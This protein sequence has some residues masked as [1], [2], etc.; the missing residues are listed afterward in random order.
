MNSAA[1]YLQRPT[2]SSSDVPSARTVP[3]YLWPAIIVVYA[4][5]MPRELTVSIGT[6]ALFPYRLALLSALPFLAFQA[7]R[8]PVRLHWIDGLVALVSSWILLSLI[9]HES[10]QQALETGLA[11]SL[12]FCLAYLVGR[13][14]I[15]STSDFRA[16][17]LAFLPGLTFIAA[18][19]LYESVAHQ[20]VLRPLIAELVGLPPPEIHDQVRF[21]L[22]R[23]A[24]P[25]PHPIL[26]GVMLATLLPVAWLMFDRGWLR[27]VSVFVAFSMI[28]T[29]STAAILVFLTGAVLM[30][31]YEVQRRSGIPVW[32]ISGIVAATL[33]GLIVAVSESGL[34]SFAAR[35]VSISEASGQWRV[36]IWEFASQEVARHPLF[37]IGLRDWERPTW[38]FTD[39]IDAHFL[40]WSVRFGLPAGGGAFAVIL[41]SAFY[42]LRNS[43]FQSYRARRISMGVA[44]SLI[45]FALSGFT[46]SLWE[47]VA[48]CG[49]LLCG[50]AVTIG[51]PPRQ[52][53]PI[54]RPSLDRI[55]PGIPPVKL[56]R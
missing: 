33:V 47:G 56:A 55:Q 17:F 5:I 36:L 21:G 10:L 46:V 2:G 4:A 14:S 15:R 22:Y 3:L 53:L 19:S 28:F 43:R 42:L 26:G 8:N 41:G 39:S 44:F 37:G 38:M 20:H 11:L 31:A 30:A 29:V 45:A 52:I 25:F 48:C 24:G 16:L 7:L 12:D 51:T 18:V 23:A 6:A 40:L 35:R 32:L 1:P 13:L 50:A 9:L 54:F 27:T 34:L 49:L